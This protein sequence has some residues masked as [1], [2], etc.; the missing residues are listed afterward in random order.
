MKLGK[1]EGVYIAARISRRGR[2]EIN[3]K[4]TCR[5]Q[6]ERQANDPELKVDFQFSHFPSTGKKNDNKKITTKPQQF[7]SDNQFG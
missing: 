1:T 7:L 5:H 2:V 4:E 6:A 3:N